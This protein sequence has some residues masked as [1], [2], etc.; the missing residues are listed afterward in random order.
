MP[1]PVRALI[2]S[3]VI[4]DPLDVIA[5]G[6]VSPDPTTFA[7]AIAVLEQR[8]VWDRV[9][10]TVR[11]HL[12]LGREGRIP[13]TP[14]PGDP[15]FEGVHAAA[16]LL[17]GGETT[18]V[19]RGEGKGGRNQEV[20]LGAALELE[21][22]DGVLVVS[23]ATDGVDGPDAA[24]AIGTGTTVQRAR[25]N[26]LDARASLDA[27]DAYP[28]FAGIGDLLMTGPTGTNVMDLM[29]VIVAV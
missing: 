21:G 13:E 17:A 10:G 1:A 29:M 24:G 28:C 9:P 20:A 19:V 3:D 27:N 2:L 7:D 6:P 8:G 4:G 23:L 22:G 15:P 11:E 5:S 14:K 12:L 25:E 18:V 16:V 26:G